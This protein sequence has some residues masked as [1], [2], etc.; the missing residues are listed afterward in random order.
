MYVRINLR[1]HFYFYTCVFYTPSQ[2]RAN[3]LS[4]FLILRNE[5]QNEFS[6]NLEIFLTNARPRVHRE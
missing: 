3:F 2:F 6:Q 4:N 1:V 5:F